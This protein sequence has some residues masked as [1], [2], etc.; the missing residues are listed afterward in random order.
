MFIL[1]SISSDLKFWSANHTSVQ[2]TLELK[3]FNSIK[4]LGRISNNWPNDL[5]GTNVHKNFESRW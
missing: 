5:Y 3:V 2:E 4:L 1:F